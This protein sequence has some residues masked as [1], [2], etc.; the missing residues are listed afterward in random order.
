[1]RVATQNI[2]L[3]YVLLSSS[4]LF[5]GSVRGQSAPNLPKA[6]K[7]LQ[8]PKDQAL[9]LQ[10]NGKGDQIYVCKKA[11]GAYTWKFKAPDAKL[12]GESGELAGRHFAGP[13]WEANDGGRVSAKSVASVPSPDSDSIPWLLLTMTSHDG[14]GIMVRV[15]SIQRLDTKGGVA[16]TS[17]CDAASENVETAV[18][19]EARYY[20]YGT[21]GPGLNGH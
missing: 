5:A 16:P 21:P 6:P 10:L 19:Y 18:P 2:V 1:M 7:I 12:F 13:S 8:P 11:G 20:F 17:G 15:Q 9:I 3:R 14:T 4:I